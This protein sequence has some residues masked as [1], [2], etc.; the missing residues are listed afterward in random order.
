MDI[1]AG[2]G[3]TSYLLQIYLDLEV[4]D[5]D[6]DNNN[7]GADDGEGAKAKCDACGKCLPYA[8]LLFLSMTESEHTKFEPCSSICSLVI[9]RTDSNGILDRPKCGLR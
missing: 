6:E 7:T 8:L 4:D 3:F 9:V 1:A 2:Q 5:T